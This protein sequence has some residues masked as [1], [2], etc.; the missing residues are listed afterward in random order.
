MRTLAMLVFGRRWRDAINYMGDNHGGADRS[1]FPPSP[2]D[3]DDARA[4]AP[5]VAM[6]VVR[7]TGN[8]RK[9]RHRARLY[10]VASRNAVR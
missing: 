8:R 3:G 7:A 9:D 5:A 1:L 2:C 10:G 4:A 6:I